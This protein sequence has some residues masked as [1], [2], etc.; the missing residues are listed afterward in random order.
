MRCLLMRLISVGGDLLKAPLKLV[1][2][3]ALN[4]FN[5]LSSNNSNL[6]FGIFKRNMIPLRAYLLWLCY[7]YH[8]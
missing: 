8:L 3:Q 5:I 4:L 1:V 7:S 6:S 2:S